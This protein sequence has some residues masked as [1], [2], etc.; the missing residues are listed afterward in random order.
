MSNFFCDMKEGEQVSLE[1]PFEDFILR[2]AIGD[3]IFIA[4]G[5][6]IARF[7]AML[8]WLFADGARHQQKQLGLLFGNRFERDIYYH[9]EFLGLAG[10]PPTFTTCRHSAVHTNRGTGCAAM[11]SSK[12][13]T[14]S[15]AGPTC[16]PTFVDWTKWSKPT[17]NCSTRWTGTESVLATKSMTEFLPPPIGK[18]SDVNQRC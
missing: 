5:T 4:T 18:D 9:D 11:C 1:G 16:P 6:G 10:Q 7:R 8:Q 17:A 12:F 15:S 3:T 2:P 13:Q 14:L